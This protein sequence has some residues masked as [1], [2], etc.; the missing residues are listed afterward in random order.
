MTIYLGLSGTILAGKGTVRE[1]IERRYRTYSISLSDILRWDLAEKGVA[2]TRENLIQY[3]NDLRKRDGADILA[4]RAVVKFEQDK[5]DCEIVL[6]D[7]VRTIAETNFL[8]QKFAG[9]FK[10]LFVDA[11]IELRYERSLKRARADEEKRSFEQF[12]ANEEAEKGKSGESHVQQLVACKELADHI[13]I[14]DGSVH[15]LE[16][17]IM[18]ILE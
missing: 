8:K 10:F 2:P 7:S 12:R 6:F 13:I 9:S 5:P 16:E 4:K 1:I 15:E 11:P 14:N 18:R 17:K 3:A